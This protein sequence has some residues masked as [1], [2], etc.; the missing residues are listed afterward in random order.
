MANDR[1]ELSVSTEVLE[2]MAELAAKEVDGVA[3][4]QT[5]KAFQKWANKELGF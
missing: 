2:K 4:P 1:T 3:G 5:F